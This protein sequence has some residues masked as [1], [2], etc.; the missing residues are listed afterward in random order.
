VGKI[1][2]RREVKKGTSFS[3]GKNKKSLSRNDDGGKT[4][5][6]GPKL[7]LQAVVV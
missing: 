2:K 1:K 6:A 3:G 7:S 5:K 4:S